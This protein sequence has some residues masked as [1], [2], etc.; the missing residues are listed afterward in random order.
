[1]I[2][3]NGKFIAEKTNIWELIKGT[4]TNEHKIKEVIEEKE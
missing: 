4:E 1:M 3:F 2:Y